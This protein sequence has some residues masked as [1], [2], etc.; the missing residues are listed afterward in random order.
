MER[1]IEWKIKEHQNGL[2]EWIQLHPTEASKDLQIHMWKSSGDWTLTMAGGSVCISRFPTLE[3]VMAAAETVLENRLT[4]PK[5]RAKS[6]SSSSTRQ[7]KS[8]RSTSG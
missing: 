1:K 2:T 3:S 4:P 7:R 8:R 5:S 6:S